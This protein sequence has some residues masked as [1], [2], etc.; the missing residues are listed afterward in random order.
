MVN[1]T[2]GNL[3][4]TEQNESNLAD[5]DMKAR[6]DF[7]LN[8]SRHYLDRIVYEDEESSQLDS[9]S[10]KSWSEGDL[11]IARLTEDKV[12]YNTEVLEVDGTAIQ[13]RFRDYGNVAVA[14]ERF[15]V[16]DIPEEDLLVNL[17]DVHLV[18][19]SSSGP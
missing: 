6:Q 13:V 15:R 9:L 8:V 18:F 12:W 10:A 1:G 19:I 5:L 17:L 4:I 7:L 3:D 14:V 2:L 16:E 11:C